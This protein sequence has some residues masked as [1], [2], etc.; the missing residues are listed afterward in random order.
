MH[1]S[2]WSAQQGAHSKERTARS[3]QQGAH[4]KER[5]ARSAQQGAHSKDEIVAK[6]FVGSGIYERSRVPMLEVSVTSEISFIHGSKLRDGNEPFQ[7]MPGQ[8]ISMSSI[9]CLKS[10][11]VHHSNNNWIS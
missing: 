10:F 7:P 3:A 9:D 1:R 2:L 4:S 8:R 5:T 11:W 6:G